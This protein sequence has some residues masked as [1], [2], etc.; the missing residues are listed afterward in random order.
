MNKLHF[1]PK[2][3]KLYIGTF[4]RGVF[5]YDMNT[6]QT[7]QPK[8]S[9]S[10]ISIN[11][12]KPL[13]N[14][15][16]LIATDGAGVFKMNMDS[17]HTTPYVVADYNK[18]NAMNGNSINDIYVDDEDRIWM[19]NYPIGITVRNNRYSSYN[20]IKP[21]SYTH[22][23]SD[24]SIAGLASEDGRHLAMMPHLERAIFPWQ[25]AYY[26]TDRVNSDQVTPWIEAFVN[27]RKWVEKNMK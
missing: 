10:D 14:K 16:L 2:V 18:N 8:E 12:I 13:N 19:A 5:V 4:Q 24:Y 11:T 9:L 25:N 27:A 23:G 17:Y 20:W 7:S 22:L 3:R 15:E 6:K 26:P 21:V 1:D